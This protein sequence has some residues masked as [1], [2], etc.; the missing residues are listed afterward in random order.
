MEQQQL[1]NDLAKQFG[2]AQTTD[3]SIDF[4][5]NQANGSTSMPVPEKTDDLEST[6]KK[7][8]ALAQ[9]V[10]QGKS[11]AEITDFKLSTH[12][13]RDAQVIA[14]ERMTPSEIMQYDTWA[15]G[16]SMESFDWN[17]CRSEVPL[18]VR[19]ATRFKR[20]ALATQRIWKSSIPDEQNASWLFAHA[21]HL[22]PLITAVSKVISAERDLTGG[23]TD[24]S[25]TD[26]AELQTIHKITAT[27]MSNLN[28]ISARL[29]AQSRSINYS[30]ETLQARENSIQSKRSQAG[31]SAG[32]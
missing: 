7:L 21:A 10:R 23:Q 19:S 28:T 12:Q 30:R 24:L 29:K 11:L 27:A 1:V 15:G 18:S 20:Y 16:A 9:V 8:E 26:M 2:A 31:R 6:A 13:R 22:V 32:T 4:N 3:N 17:I 25:E 5:E 14:R